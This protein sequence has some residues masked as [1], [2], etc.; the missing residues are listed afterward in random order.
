MEVA[1]MII[2]T[3]MCSISR[4]GVAILELLERLGIDLAYP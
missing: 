4:W 1:L 3:S 2:A